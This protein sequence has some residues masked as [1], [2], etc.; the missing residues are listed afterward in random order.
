[1]ASEPSDHKTSILPAV[2]APTETAPAPVAPPPAAPSGGPLSGQSTVMLEAVS[3]PPPR[4]SRPTPAP[5]SVVTPPPTTGRFERMG[6]RFEAPPAAPWGHWLAGPLLA[7]VVAIATTLLLRVVW[8]L[9]GHAKPVVAEPGRLKLVS[10]PPNATITVDG[11]VLPHFTPTSIEAN[12]GATLKVSFKLDGYTPKEEEVYI[13]PGEH[14]FSVKLQPMVAAPPPPVVTPEPP[15]AEVK[16]A[17]TVA[18][19]HKKKRRASGPGTISVF[20]KPWAIVFVD[21]TRLRQTPLADFKLA[22]GSHEI[23]LVN[24]SKHQRERITVEVRPGTVQEIRRNW[25]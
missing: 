18:A 4:A 14:S 5:S 13:A 24:E 2:G 25:E 6:P 12:V 23:E 21:G 3:L 7:V 17:A 11:N 1:M 15:P 10:D 9:G 20:V 8:P 22:S 16:P 19:D